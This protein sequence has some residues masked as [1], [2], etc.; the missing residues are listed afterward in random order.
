MLIWIVTEQAL[1]KESRGPLFYKEKRISQGKIFMFYK[2]RTFKVKAI[3]AA[4]KAGAVIHTAELQR[5]PENLTYYG[6]FFKKIYMDELPQLWNVLRGDM[7]LVGPRPTN[8]VNST[9]YK[10]SGDYTREIIICGLTGPYQAQKGG[11]GRQF[12]LDKEYIEFVSHNPGWK[13]VLR[14]IKII[15][16]TINVVWQAKGI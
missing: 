1:L 8:L 2:W 15:L 11:T 9:N 5:K 6:K 4:L 10:N 3:E 16:K 14:D 12:E 13:V 7:T